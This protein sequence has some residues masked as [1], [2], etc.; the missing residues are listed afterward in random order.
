M[1]WRSVVNFSLVL[2]LATCR[3]RSSPCDTVA[4]FCARPVLCWLAFPSAPAL[5][6]ADSAADRSTAF[7]GFTATMAGSD[8]SR[9][10][11]IGYG[12]SPSRCG[13]WGRRVHRPNVRPPRFRRLPFVRDVF[14]D[15]GRA[16]VPRIAG[17]HMLPSTLLTGSASAVLWLSRLNSTPHTIAVY[18]SHPPSPATTQHSLP[19][20]RYGLP[21]PVSHRQDN[22]SLPGA[23]AIHRAKN[24]LLRR[25]APRNDEGRKSNLRR[26]DLVADDDK[27]HQIHSP[28]ARGQRHVGGVAAGAHQD[29]ADPRMIVAGVEGVPLAGQIDLEP[30]GKIHRCG[31]RRNADVAHIAGAIARRD[32][33]A[34]A[35]GQRQMREIATDAGALLID[36]VRGLH[37][38]R[39]LV[40]EGDVVVHVAADR[41]D[42]RPARRGIAEQRPGDV[43]QLVG[44]AIAARHQI[45]QQVV[46]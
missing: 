12:S 24:G 43:G 3:M 10:C 16:S 41:G 36:V 7:T 45:E 11:I 35:E 23:Q 28:K 32:A 17:P 19:G 30:A 14:F 9:S 22:A 2:C 1:W 29:P 4:R 34:A 25:F 20:A 21:G 31:I 26:H 44:F 8:F 38:I 46:G 18:A 39:M 5:G 37:V 6:S 33:H 42:P 15:H 13:P 27:L 40:A